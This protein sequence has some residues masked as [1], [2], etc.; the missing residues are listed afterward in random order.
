MVGM[1]ADDE[2]IFPR[3]HL[4][5]WE[6]ERYSWNLLSENPLYGYTRVHQLC[7]DFRFH[8]PARPNDTMLLQEPWPSK[9]VLSD[10]LTIPTAS[11]AFQRPKQSDDHEKTVPLALDD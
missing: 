4:L 11:E 2:N 3:D 8:R 5:A 9:L 7:A 10:I 6:H 1:Y